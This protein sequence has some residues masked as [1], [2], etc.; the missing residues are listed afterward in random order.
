ML[1]GSFLRSSGLNML[2]GT[3]LSDLFGTP[4]TTNNT[5]PF[6]VGIA[7]SQPEPTVLVHQNRMSLNMGNTLVTGA[8]FYVNGNAAIGYMNSAIA[9]PANGLFVR[10]VTAIGATS[11]SINP[12]FQ[13]NV[14][15]SPEAA[16]PLLVQGGSDAPFLIW[17]RS[18]AGANGF[19]PNHKMLE[20]ER[21]EDGVAFR[22]YASGRT[23]VGENPKVEGTIQAGGIMCAQRVRVSLTP[24]CVP[25]YVFDPGYQLMPLDEVEA[26]VHTHRHL[27]GV[28]SA[29]ELTHDGTLELS[30][31]LLKT[32]EKVEE[33]T[34]YILQLQKRVQELEQSR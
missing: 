31:L 15:G 5:V 28:P 22:V 32:L 34:L 19:N 3:G 11:N 9:P 10:G 14:L 6:S 27:P 25:D 13:L 29:Q 12:D 16:N 33:Q 4:T 1:L 20:L 8:N 21:F 26:Y 17:G 7:T 30:E 18:T 24:D 23:E 2:I